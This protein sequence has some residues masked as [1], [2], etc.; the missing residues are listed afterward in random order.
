MDVVAFDGIGAEAWD[1]FL[2]SSPDAWFWH[3]RQYCDFFLELQKGKG[4]SDLSFA[5]VEDSRVL[6]LCPMYLDSAQEVPQLG[7]GE[8]F[9]PFAALADRLSV[10]ERERVLEHY[11]TELTRLSKRYLAARARLRVSPLSENHIGCALRPVSPLV[12]QGFLDLTES[13][14]VIDLREDEAM[15]W[16]NVRKGHRYDVRRAEK[17]CQ[18]VF[19]TKESITPQAFS[20][21][22]ALHHKDAGRITR[23]QHSFDIMLGWIRSG[24]A[25]LAE[26]TR[27]GESMAFALIILFGNGSYYGSGCKD[28]DTT[29]LNAS[30]MLQWKSILW[31]KA[32]GVDYYETGAQHFGA[33]WFHVASEKEIGIAKYKRGFGGITIPVYSGEIFYQTAALQKTLAVRFD[34]LSSA[35]V[36]NACADEAA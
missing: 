15:L 34:R 5:L 27:E 11:F 19:W 20:R 32:F 4:V 10:A 36:E 25:V 12:R 3:T 21:Y 31:L 26:A 13:T 16:T 24:Y 30:H 17:T 2:V 29:E 18:T 8:D 7:V 6:A 23:S 28:P 9:V 35:F 22:Q 1:A 14:Q 33:Q